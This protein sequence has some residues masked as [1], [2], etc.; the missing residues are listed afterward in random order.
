MNEA[1]GIEA[2]MTTITNGINANSIWSNINAVLP[3]VVVMTGVAISVYFLKRVLKKASRV[4]A[5]L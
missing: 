2:A 5:G 3:F 4:Q 1:T